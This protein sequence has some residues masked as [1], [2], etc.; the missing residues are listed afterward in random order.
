MEINKQNTNTHTHARYWVRGY[1]SIRNQTQYL[2]RFFLSLFSLADVFFYCCC[3]SLALLKRTNRMRRERKWCHFRKYQ[4]TKHVA[5]QIP[6]NGTKQWNKNTIR[7]R[8][9]STGSLSIFANIHC[10]C[11]CILYCKL[12]KLMCVCVCLCSVQCGKTDLINY[13]IALFFSTWHSIRYESVT[14]IHL[15]EK[16]IAYE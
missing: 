13:M 12:H 2:E 15:S 10:C 7:I 14:S 6:H 5:Q 8:I 3:F 1:H 9:H 16:F 4:H 11:C